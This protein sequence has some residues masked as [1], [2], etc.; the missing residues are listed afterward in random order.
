MVRDSMEHA[1]LRGD[2]LWDEPERFGHPV[3]A[4]AQDALG[5]EKPS[6]RCGDFLRNNEKAEEQWELERRF[7][8]FEASVR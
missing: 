7:R 5:A 3:S 1:F 2:S 8:T 6:V 4:C